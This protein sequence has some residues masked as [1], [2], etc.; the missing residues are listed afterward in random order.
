[1][2]RL[3]SDYT[4]RGLWLGL[5]NKDLH[6]SFYGDTQVRGATWP[7]HA[8]TTKALAKIGRAHV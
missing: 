7:C 1:M 6:P 8:W 2:A 3:E 5:F 4:W